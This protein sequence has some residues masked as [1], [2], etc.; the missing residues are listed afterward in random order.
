MEALGALVVEVVVSA[1]F[2]AT[3]LNDLLVAEVRA[4]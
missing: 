2:L 4:V 1:G 3:P